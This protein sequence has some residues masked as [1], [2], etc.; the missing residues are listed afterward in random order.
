M[1]ELLQD[2]IGCSCCACVVALHLEM[3]SIAFY[4]GTEG[5]DEV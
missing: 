3:I 2:R 4:D 1:V 5:E